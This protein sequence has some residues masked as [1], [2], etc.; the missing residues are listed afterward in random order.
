MCQIIDNVL[1]QDEASMSFVNLHGIRIRT[2]PGQSTN[3]LVDKSQKLL[4][5][6]FWKVL[7]LYLAT[8]MSKMAYPEMDGIRSERYLLILGNIKSRR[9]HRKLQRCRSSRP[10]TGMNFQQRMSLTTCSIHWASSEFYPGLPK[11][12]NIVDDDDFLRLPPYSCSWDGA[13]VKQQV[14]YS[15]GSNV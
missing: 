1:T 6:D 11:N 2:T 3:N 9:L 14:G 13:K 5:G 4:L 15:N 7:R 10:D 8:I 12:G